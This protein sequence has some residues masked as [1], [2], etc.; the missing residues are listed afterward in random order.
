M[1]RLRVLAYQTASQLKYCSPLG[2]LLM[3]LR[4]SQGLK[5]VGEKTVQK[6]EAIGAMTFPVLAQMTDEQFV[7]AGIPRKIG[8]RIRTYVRRRIR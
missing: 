1:R 8:N 7:A 4:R 2:V 5:G 3:E 6:L